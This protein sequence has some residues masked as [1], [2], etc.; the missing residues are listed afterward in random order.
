MLDKMNDFHFIPTINFTIDCKYAF[1][2]LS[3]LKPRLGKM[4]SDSHQHQSLSDFSEQY[5]K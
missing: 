5:C 1:L 2:H 3:N 4:K